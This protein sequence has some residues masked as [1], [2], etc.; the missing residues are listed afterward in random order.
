MT[1]TRPKPSFW[2]SFPVF[3]GMGPEGLATLASVARARS[4]P[5]GATMFQRGDP[6]DWLFAI[7]DGRVRLTVATPGGRELVLRHAEAGDTLGEIALFD[8]EPR[9]ADAVAL[10]PVS[11]WIVHG[12]DWQRLAATDPG[13][14]QA[15]MR[16]LCRRLRETT[17]Q[18]ES[19][20]LFDLEA[21]AARFLLATLRQLHG[22]EVPAQAA[23]RLEISQTEIAAVLAAS[24]SKVNRA[25]AALESQGATRR[26]G[27]VTWCD[28]SRL[29]ALAE[30]SA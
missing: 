12:A 16:W 28:V 3:E 17:G 9:S 23:L 5:A 1:D 29:T 25:L 6:G 21:R 2:R 30:G 19:I 24:R 27:N 4:W 10:T 8:G 22:E 20:A 18:L 14:T 11:G 26:E 7:A 15:G 13:V